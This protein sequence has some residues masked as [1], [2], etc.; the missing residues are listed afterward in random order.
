[1]G[2]YVDIAGHS[3][4]VEETG[5]GTETVLLLHGG[6]SSS[7]DLLGTI[8]PTLADH[9]RVVAFDRRGHGR[10][11][12][13]D[14]PFHYA[15]M[16]K[17]AI[18]VLET[19]VGGPA[20]LVGFSD[21]GNIAL[22]IALDRPEL[23]G[24]I[25]PIGA[26]FHHD[27]LLPLPFS[28]DSPAIQMIADAYAE[29]SPDGREHFEVTMQKALAMFAAEPTLT[30]DDLHRIECPALVIAGDDDAIALPHTC[31]LFEALPAGELAIV[32]GASHLVP[33]EKPLDVAHLVLAFLQRSGP[34]ATFMPIRRS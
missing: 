4:W 25:V 11:A 5:S 26:N 14:E 29:H 28:A 17:E 24:K 22:L 33:I 6:L 19:V 12:D 8:G 7:D 15:D 34:P 18:A 1:M 13:T 9:Y 23:V 27:G 32:P 16:A 21:G 30:V 10:T 2:R 20:H 31:A 3:T